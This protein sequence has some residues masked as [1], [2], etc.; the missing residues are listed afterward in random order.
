MLFKILKFHNFEKGKPEPNLRS[1]RRSRSGAARARSTPAYGAASAA[2]REHVRRW[3]ANSPR[4]STVGHALGPG[5]SRASRD[6]ADRAPA[7]RRRR[8]A[9][10]PHVR[11]VTSWLPSGHALVATPPCSPSPLATYKKVRTQLPRARRRPPWPPPR[12]SAVHSLPPPFK[13]P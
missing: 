6:R 5:C 12:S 10:S 9:A 11:H 1:G 4:V 3:S 2:P 7:T 13:H 8:R